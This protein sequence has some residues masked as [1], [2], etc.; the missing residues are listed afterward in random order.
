MVRKTDTHLEQASGLKRFYRDHGLL[1]WSIL[2]IFIPLLVG[3]L[4]LRD[5]LL[6]SSPQTSGTIKVQGI[7]APFTLSRDINGVVIIESEYDEDAFFAV[8]LA[9]A[10][11]RLWQLELQRRMSR[12]RLSE[13]F[14]RGSLGFDVFI[15]TIGIYRDAE[16]SFD[17]LS[18][19][20]KKSLIAYSNGINSWIDSADAFP[21]E[22][23][24]LGITPEKWTPVDSIAWIKMFALNLSSNYREELGNL[25]LAQKLPP[26]KI[27]S[28]L[29]ATSATEAGLTSSDSKALSD[30]SDFVS[31][32]A[33]LYA[34]VKGREHKWGIGAD[35]V[36]S[37]AWVVSQRLSASGGVTLANDPH[38]AL[39]LPSMWYTVK[40]NS[41]KLK[42]S[43]MSLVGLPI[44]M[45]GE[46]NNIA[47]G[48][49]NMMADT[50]DL[51]YERVN[52]ENS[53][54]YL[55]NGEWLD[56]ETMDEEIHVKAD[57]PA[58]LRTPLA[59]VNIKIRK[60]LNGPLISD[61]VGSMENPISFK[62]TGS[63]KNDGSYGAFYA[64]NYAHDW[65]SFNLAMSK[66]V[67][68]ALNLLYIDK[69]QNIGQLGVGRVPIRG[70]G[71]GKLP[72]KGWDKENAWQGYIPFEGMPRVLNPDKGYIVNANNRNVDLDFPYFI[73]DSWADPTRADRIA[74]LIEQKLSEKGN[75][76]MQDSRQIQLDSIDL[77]AHDLLPEL[78]D[79]DVKGDKRL[80]EMLNQLEGWNGATDVQSVP[81]TIFFT[82]LYYLREELLN[83]DFLAGRGQPA[84][85]VLLSY[86]VSDM[87]LLS[88]SKLLN[89]AEADWCDK[90][91]TTV[92][93]DCQSIKLSSLKRAE[94]K[95]DRL[96]GSDI[97]DWQWGEIHQSVYSHRPFSNIRGMDML[98]ERRA[99]SSG[100][101]NSVNV[102]GSNFQEHEGFTKVYGAGFRQIVQFNENKSRYEYI[103]STGQS[104]NFVSDH[105]DDMI[106]LYNKGSYLDLID[107]KLDE[108]HRLLVVPA[109]S[110]GA[111]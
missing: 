59:P 33:K 78:I 110:T 6:Q 25:L 18:E 47:W 2:F 21:S 97:E 108:T 9:H 82:W 40:I 104:G 75:L 69:Q 99:Q 74:D 28:M 10:Q 65:D 42:V 106:A 31:T 20:A 8:G 102:A 83:D 56:F 58:F 92:R 22:F 3:A 62:W 32:A 14:G 72:L 51:Y 16:E 30:N 57:F 15:R 27:E 50:Q 88:I 98:Y 91:N 60:T 46:N 86:A 11:D 37:N 71:I 12:G 4:F 79:V 1:C 38:L 66:N 70:Q 67:A 17:V 105:Y 7:K 80:A 81:A 73:S 48:V 54:Q 61:T 35:A 90:I 101:L 63:E 45:L 84:S 52:I 94:S 96:L 53:N 87:T 23:K 55:H 39:E 26:L 5:Q 111:N 109:N 95:L 34:D 76:S 44:V 68:P 41:K 13:I 29:R 49:T 103:N 36:G 100:S 85:N 93:E 24:V 43:G 77:R 64:L 107:L 19:D 89:E